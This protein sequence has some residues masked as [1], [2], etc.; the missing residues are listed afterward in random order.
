MS[1]HIH[2]WFFKPTACHPVA[3]TFSQRNYCHTQHK[4]NYCQTQA[5]LPLTCYG[6]ETQNDHEGRDKNVS[7][8]AQGEHEKSTDGCT[9]GTTYKIEDWVENVDGTEKEE[10]SY[11]IERETTTNEGAI[12]VRFGPEQPAWLSL[13]FTGTEHCQLVLKSVWDDV[14]ERM[15]DF[16]E[17]VHFRT[18]VRIKDV[19]SFESLTHIEEQL[20]F[21]GEPE[22]V[23]ELFERRSLILYKLYEMEVQKR[24]DENLENFNPVEPSVNYDYMCIRFLSPNPI[25]KANNADYQGPIPSNLQ[26][27]VY[28][29]NREETIDFMDSANNEDS[30]ND[31]SQQVFVSSPPTTLHADIKLEEV[32]VVSLDS[33]MTSMDSKLRKFEDAK[34]QRALRRRAK[35]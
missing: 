5:T 35:K 14:S 32:E 12:V 33:R 18:S 3:T 10:R 2:D 1:S 6:C 15:V 20:L 30:S 7:T 28:T 29:E 17:W 27:V 11:H 8:I 24:V 25:S 13:T 23:S 31:G 26:T 22:Q 21:W 19:S 9:E 16:D 4:R 34:K